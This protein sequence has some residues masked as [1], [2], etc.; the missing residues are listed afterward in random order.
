MSPLRFP[1]LFSRRS[2]RL[3]GL[4]SRLPGLYSCLAGLN[5]MRRLPALGLPGQGVSRQESAEL[6]RRVDRKPHRF[7]RGR[8]CESEEEGM[9][10]DAVQR[11][12]LAAI[13]PVS[14][15]GMATV[16]QL[17]PDLILAA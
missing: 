5:L 2:S 9:Q 3:P 1:D 11:V 17:R 6:Q 12:G 10:P 8:M 7:A 16:R 14:G 15:D 13:G 4:Y